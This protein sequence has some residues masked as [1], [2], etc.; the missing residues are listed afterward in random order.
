LLTTIVQIVRRLEQVAEDLPT[1]DL[2]TEPTDAIGRE[3]D[4]GIATFNKLK[5]GLAR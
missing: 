1:T 3:I 5:G 2:T 4:Q